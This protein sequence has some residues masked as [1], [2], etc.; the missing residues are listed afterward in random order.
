MVCLLMCR[1]DGVTPYFTFWK[2]G[3]KEHVVQVLSGGTLPEPGRIT[4]A[5][6]VPSV[7]A[8]G[9]AAFEL[10]SFGYSPTGDPSDEPS[11]RP[12]GWVTSGAERWPTRPSCAAVRRP[13]PCRRPTTPR[14]PR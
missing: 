5:A 4:A 10:P 13:G 11:G 1:D 2:H 3:L 7:E 12:A 6:T 8:G 14:C 9:P